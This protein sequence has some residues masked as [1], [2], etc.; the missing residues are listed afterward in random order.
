[1]ATKRHGVKCYDKAGLDEPLFVLRGQD[2]SSPKIVLEWIKDNFETVSEEK[3]RKA[4]DAALAM[5]RWS[6]RKAAD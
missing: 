3:L 1:M 2:T 5:K 4:F 6:P